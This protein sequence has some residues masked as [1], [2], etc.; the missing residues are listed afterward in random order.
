MTAMRR[1]SLALVASLVAIGLLAAPSG[2]GMTYGT[3]LYMS[4]RFP[5]FHGKIHSSN[6]FCVAHRKVKVYKVRSGP[7]KL[8]GAGHSKNDGH[9]KVIIKNLSSGAFYSRAPLYGSASLGITCRADRSRLAVA[10]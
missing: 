10:D 9:W 5:G 3:H 2:A 6:A 1:T 7:D 4:K 8:L